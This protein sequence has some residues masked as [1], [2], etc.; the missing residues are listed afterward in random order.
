MT[1]LVSY[2]LHRRYQSITNW[3]QNQRS[4][5]KKK[6][7]DDN[8]SLITATLKADYPH[9]T[10]HYSAFPPPSH[11]S[12]GFP[13]PSLHPSL[14]CDPVLLRRSP[15]VSPSRSPRRSSSRR[16]ITPYG[17]V[18]AA[19]SRPRRSR[20]EPYQ[21]DALKELYKQ[22]STPTIEE[23]SALALEIGMYV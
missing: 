15:S 20:P 3:F 4:L 7:E 12:L 22:T 9:E 23:R 5:A 11:P 10:R 21:L 18:S 13:L 17:T 2:F 19:F 8:E 1:N 14:T 16:S 6:K